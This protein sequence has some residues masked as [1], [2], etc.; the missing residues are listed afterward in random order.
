MRLPAR[1]AAALALIAC[2][3]LL[4]SPACSTRG[5]EGFAIYLTRDNVPAAQMEAL[6]HV[7][8][9][10]QPTVSME[11][12]V[13]YDEAT[14]EMELTT[15]AFDRLADLEVPVSGTSFVVCVDSQPIY[16]G[17]FWTPISSLSF[18]GVTIWKP[19]GTQDSTVVRLELGYPS[20]SVYRGDDPRNAPEV[21]SA[22][23]RAGKLKSTSPA[24]SQAAL[25]HTMKGYELYSWQEGDLWHFTLITGTN[26]NKSAEEVFSHR[27]VVSQDGWVHIHAVG[28][29]EIES[30]LSRL[31]PGEN[32]FWLSGLRAEDGST[33]I[34]FP[35]RSVIDAVAGHAKG[36]DLNL[37]VEPD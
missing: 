36:C 29:D 15:V 10:D 21:L 27:T 17:A 24:A 28:V 34:M 12:V 4:V 8:I 6:S 32:V 31:P 3:A 37:H 13:T 9:A 5:D 7:E 18:D 30:A 22:L 25:P 11:D 20:A 1:P 35:P 23:E 2:C 16:W 14:H 26:R 19:L 33:D